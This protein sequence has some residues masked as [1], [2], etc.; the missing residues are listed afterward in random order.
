MARIRNLIQK[1]QKLKQVYA[2][3][4]KT[5]TFPE[6]GVDDHLEKAFLKRV[7]KYINEHMED[8]SFGVE[9]LAAEMSMSPSNLYRKVY[10]LTDR[11]PKQ[12]IQEAKLEQAGL[13]LKQGFNVSE[14]AYRTGFRSPSYFSQ[15]FKKHF[16]CTPREY[17]HN[18]A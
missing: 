18:Y 10:A 2:L 9:S 12:L 3:G 6:S 17:I 14:V 8:S 16:R 1:R 4:F 13:L 7:S 11:S 5:Q 15:V